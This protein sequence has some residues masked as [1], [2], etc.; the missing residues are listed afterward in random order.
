MYTLTINKKD[1]LKDVFS[2]DHILKVTDFLQD[3]VLETIAPMT[4]LGIVEK[5]Y[6]E[7]EF[8]LVRC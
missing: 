7:M 8:T 4:E 3:Y 6:M 5:N 1:G 2:F